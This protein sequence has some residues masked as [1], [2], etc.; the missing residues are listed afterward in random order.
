MNN[1]PSYRDLVRAVNQ[2]YNICRV[3]EMREKYLLAE[4]RKLAPDHEVFKKIEEVENASKKNDV[5]L[6]PSRTSEMRQP[7]ETGKFGTDS[8]P[9]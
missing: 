7:G 1:K 9:S 2:A 3:R 5:P 6:Q 4:L 8:M